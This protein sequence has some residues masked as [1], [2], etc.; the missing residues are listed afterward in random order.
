MSRLNTS[1]SSLPK[2]EWLSALVLGGCFTLAFRFPA[3]SGWGWLEA[4]MGFL[5]P[6][7]LLDTL[8]KGR[9]GF[10]IWFACFSGLVGIFHWVPSTLAL[11]GGLPFPLA[12]FSGGL[13]WAWEALGFWAVAMASRG[14][15]QR[16]GAGAAAL[17][18]ALGILVWERFGF[19]IYPWSWGATLGGLPWLARSA[20]FLGSVGLSALIWGCTAWVAANLSLGQSWRRTLALPASGL[21]L[22]IL[23]S[24]GWYLLPREAP[25]SLDIVMVQP[26]FDPGVP[27]PGMEATC[28]A[29]TDP[30]LAQAGLPRADRSTLVLWPESSVLGRDDRFRDPRLA[31]E[32]RKRGVAW[33]FGTEGGLFNLVRGEVGGRERFLMAK[34]ELMAFGE[35]N[36]GPE[37]LRQRLD[38][39][40]GMRS[41]EPGPLDA[42]SSF[43]IPTPQGPLRVHPLVCSEALLA[44]R[45][46]RGLKLAGG[47]LLTNLT[48]DGWFERSIATDLHAA[49]VRLRAVETGLPLLRA[50]LT[51]KSGLFKADGTW[52]LWGEA[53]SSGTYT[54]TLNWRPVLTPMRWPLW[55]W[56]L[57]GLLTG[58]TLLVTL[59]WKHDNS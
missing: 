10:W 36:P 6:L 51:G 15:F 54:F 9:H 5:F 12:L 13:F 2:L 33:L 3:A 35:R 43:V 19:H 28:W 58:I 56:G 25:R 8:Y 49:Q 20:A 42:G 39:W 34:A 27:L 55:S 59:S 52:E 57:F 29:L 50:T 53:R 18:A 45:V 16:K 41:Q 21:G 44:E 22:L 30:A 1:P 46:Q 38:A 11:K 31:E 32:A 4:A 40:L 17:V 47:D 23:L 24:G 26:N 37:A 7:L 14:A 48:N